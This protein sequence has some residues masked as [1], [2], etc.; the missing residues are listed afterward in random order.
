M[1]II[2]GKLPLPSLTW[3][4]AVELGEQPMAAGD[5]SGAEGA[6]RRLN[7]H[8]VD[9]ADP[10]HAQLLRWFGT[11]HVLPRLRA[12]TETRPI[13]AAGRSYAGQQIGQAT[14]LLSWLAARG[15][16]LADCGQADVDAWAVEHSVSD[17]VN[18]RAFLQWSATNRLSPRF[19]LPAAQGAGG[20]PLPERDRT[21]LPGQLVT[22]DSSPL[23]SRITPLA[24]DDIIRDDDQVLLRLGDPPSPVPESVAALLLEYLGQRTNMRNATRLAADAGTTWAACAQGEHS[25]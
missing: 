23:R 9:V 19:E 16:A 7:Q 10:D 12:R 4:P 17:R 21:V 20:A 13:T 8:L 11:W 15:R 25:Q 2:R 18:V 6:L 1:L 3:R 24:I 5:T 22:D 14:D